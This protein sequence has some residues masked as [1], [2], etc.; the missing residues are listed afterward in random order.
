MYAIVLTGGKQYTLKEG[1]VVKVDRLEGDVGST[2]EMNEV[3]FLKKDET[4]T[5]VG[6]PLVPKTSV[7]CKVLEQ[8]RNKKILVFKKKRRK[9]F[10]KV[11]GHR[12]YYTK[13]LVEKINA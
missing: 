9:G 3:V 1:D 12:S 5:L 7:T 13:V 8:D 4:T 2:I 6:S 11:R 10:R